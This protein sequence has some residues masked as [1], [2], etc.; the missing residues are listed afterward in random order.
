MWCCREKK[1][2]I[3]KLIRKYEKDLNLNEKKM[4]WEVRKYFMNMG[5]IVKIVKN[6]FGEVICDWIF[7]IIGL[8]V[9]LMV[10]VVRLILELFVG[11][12]DKIILDF[13]L[14]VI[15][16]LGLIV[17][18]F[19]GINLVNKEIEKCIVYILVVKFL[20]CLELIVGKYIGLLVV[21]VVLLIV[22][23]VIYGLIFS[24]SGIFYFIGSILV[25]VIFIFI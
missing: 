19:I 15:S 6:V 12:D 25:I 13:G 21:L 20:S 8:F 11:I 22:M 5:R 10:V 7:Y 4:K 3:R 2:Y 14:V 16:I 18:V 24:L 1:C 17:I 9:L 23:I